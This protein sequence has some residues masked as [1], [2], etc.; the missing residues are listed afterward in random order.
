MKCRECERPIGT[1][2]DGGAYFAAEDHAREGEALCRECC[3]RAIQ[4]D[5]HSGPLDGQTAIVQE[6]ATAIVLLVEMPRSGAAAPGR[7]PAYPFHSGPP[8]PEYR[9][10]RYKKRP[11]RINQYKFVGYEP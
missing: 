10:V 1:L 5:L 9:N 2:K 6:G 8:Q 4:V 3:E 7:D 11:G